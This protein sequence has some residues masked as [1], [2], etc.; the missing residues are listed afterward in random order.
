ML[1]RQALNVVELLEFFAA[2]G[3]PATL[4]EIADELGWPRSSTFN[5]L[6]TLS[7][8]GY[9]YEPRVKGGFFP[10]PSI[11]EIAR[12]IGE[13]E[14]LPEEL[15]RLAEDV[16]AA[17]GETTA[18]CAPSGVHALFLHVV[19]SSAMI[20]YFAKVG[21][22]S[23]MHSS[24]SG[25]ALLAQFSEAERHMLYRRMDFEGFTPNSPTDIAEVEARLKKGIARGYHSSTA[26]YSADLVG[27][28]VSL[29]H[30]GRRLSLVTGGPI[31]RCQAKVDEFGKLVRSRAKKF[32]AE[33]S[34]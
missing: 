8:K 11:C 24:S 27:V 2:R 33:A 1:V 28:A 16:A 34:V 26:E 29:Q 17:T 15:E 10:S 3:R 18:I 30:E 22:R 5:L 6:S 20:R 7:M 13:A 9:L 4:S 23:P 21:S 31:S 12:Q 25:R 32:L 19:E 14:P